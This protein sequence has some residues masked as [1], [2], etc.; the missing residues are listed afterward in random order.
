[1]KPIAAAGLLAL[2]APLLAHAELQLLIV[3]QGV[4]TPAGPVYELGQVASGDLRTA[5]VRIRNTGEAGLAITR[6][7]ASGTGFSLSG[8]SLP[9]SIL[10]GAFR[11]L[12]LHFRAEAPA[13]YSA[14]VQVNG[15]SVLVLAEVVAPAELTASEPC[16]AS[17]PFTIAFGEIA[18]GVSL[19]CTFQ[20]TN[21]SSASLTVASL[22][23][24]GDA[25]E[26]P[27]GLPP[28]RE[29]P[30][31]LAGGETLPFTIRFQ[32]PR[33]GF[34]NGT[35]RIG[36]R[37]YTLTGSAANP[38]LPAPMLDWESSP[39]GSGQQRRLTVRLPQ[40]APFDASGLLTLAFIP[41][42]V[43]AGARDDATV[44]FPAHSS[45][46]LSFS[47]AEGA[48]QVLLD[49]QPFAIFQTGTTAGRIEFDFSGVIEGFT[50][51]PARTLTVPAEP[52]AIQS[53]SAGRRPGNLDLAMTGF[54]NTH[55]TGP[56]A[57]TFFDVAGRGVG[58]PIRA[59]FSDAF[60]SYYAA[61]ET[62]GAFQLLLRFPVSGDASGIAE[63]EVE[64][65]TSG[66]ITRTQRVRFP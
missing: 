56:M 2:F 21:P 50:S 47:V 27:V 64:F 15:A 45:R 14:N 12:T 43:V 44:M 60:Q 66:G 17:A 13:H 3:D 55:A 24:E 48:T 8:P 46:H 1:M 20:L 28:G 62:G 57:F 59:D 61:T 35:L 49:G 9:F 4:E 11:D 52:V 65:T 31:T 19:N 10:G 23:V 63:V 51:D 33:A 32:P 30:F 5:R 16:Q 22:S 53:A 38:A 7:S 6:Y 58:G 42:S 41:D 40:P 39:V 37:S 36:T 34:Y 29:A 18:Q 54:D 26:G 25:F